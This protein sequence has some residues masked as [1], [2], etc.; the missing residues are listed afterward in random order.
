MRGRKPKPT[1]LQIAA[2]DPRMRGKRKLE[3]KEASHPRA[4]TGLP[5]CPDRFQG[6]AREA[7]EYWRDQLEKMRLAEM[8]DALTLER[9]AVHYALASEADIPFFFA[10]SRRPPRSR[11]ILVAHV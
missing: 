8:P 11:V 3:Q 7:Y 10:G 9:A 6:M 5:S 4:E 2:G 1:R